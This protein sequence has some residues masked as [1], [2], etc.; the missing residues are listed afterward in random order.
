MADK[1]FRYK[2]KQPLYGISW[3]SRA[4]HPLRLAISSYSESFPNNIQIVKLNQDKR[5]F[6]EIASMQTMYPLTKIQFL[7]STDT[8]NPDLIATAS[9]CLRILEINA[10]TGQLHN[11]G[12]LSSLED[13]SVPILAM[14]WCAHSLNVIATANSDTTVSLWDIYKQETDLQFVAHD[15]AVSDINFSFKDPNVFVTSGLDGSIRWFDRR[16][17]HC[18]NELYKADA[19]VLRCKFSLD[20]SNY[21]AFIV[22]KS[23]EIMIM[24]LRYPTQPCMALRGHKGPVNGVSWSKSTSGFLVSVGVDREAFLWEIA[25][26]LEPFMGYKA[27]HPQP[28]SS[29]TAG[30]SNVDWS[31]V[32]HEW[33]GITV[34]D[35]LEILHL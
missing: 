30:I 32:N 13:A 12:R 20:D 21:V 26:D 22:D 11:R 35:T 18:A 7:P 34:D 15:K 17:M 6:D 14:D 9:D 31:F 33:V 24:D 1:L 4:D 3:S 27:P 19:P 16:R 28:Q 29:G 10:K 5:K 2:A 25:R 23:S 8:S